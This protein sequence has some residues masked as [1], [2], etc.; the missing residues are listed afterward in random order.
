MCR[1]HPSMVLRKDNKDHSR[2]H[3]GVDFVPKAVN[4]ETR[5]TPFP[6]PELNLTVQLVKFEIKI[7]TQLKTVSNTSRIEMAKAIKVSHVVKCARK[8][9]I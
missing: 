2:E 6:T 5:P 9:V 8:L 4:L 3:Y 7:I 1:V